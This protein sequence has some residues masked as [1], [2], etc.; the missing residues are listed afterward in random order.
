M[1]QRATENL[2]IEILV[3]GWLVRRKRRMKERAR[4]LVAGVAMVR[5][6][7][8]A[9][10]LFSAAQAKSARAA[11][12][13]AAAEELEIAAARVASNAMAVVEAEVL[14]PVVRSEIVAQAVSQTAALEVSALEMA[15]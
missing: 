10:R 2:A 9:P 5:L 4:R 6:E 1:A 3:I 13:L 8:L 14:P 7:P 15:L 12:P 11:K